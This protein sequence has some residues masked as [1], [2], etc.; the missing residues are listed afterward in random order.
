MSSPPLDD[1]ILL[2]SFSVSLTVYSK[3]KK[4]SLKGKK[5]SKEEKSMKMKELL[6]ALDDSNYTEFLQAILHKHGLDGYT[7]TEKRH[8]PLKYIPPKA[9][10]YTPT[11]RHVV[12]GGNT[13][14][15]PPI[16]SPSQ[17]SHYLQ[18]AKSHLGVHHTLS[19]KSTLKMNRIGP[20]IF[21]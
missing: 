19:Y 5:T 9:K 15:S 1:D 12:E 11:W 18:Y 13:P 14:P 3:V 2:Q 10:G 8:F 6:F 4:V 7:V 16:P 21:P 20:Y 17:L